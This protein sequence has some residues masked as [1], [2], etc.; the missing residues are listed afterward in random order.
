MKGERLR[1]RDRRILEALKLMGGEASTRQIAIAANLNTNGVS[2][3]LGV[4]ASKGYVQPVGGERGDF[5]WRLQD[6]SN[7]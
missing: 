1:K 5:L 6:L 7:Y 2:Q 3:T 4:L